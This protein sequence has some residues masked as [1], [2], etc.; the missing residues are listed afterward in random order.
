M[1]IGGYIMQINTPQI[2]SYFS[3]ISQ[4]EIDAIIEN[5]T[6]L[7]I[8]K[9]GNSKLGKLIWDFSLPPVSSCPDSTKC[10]I[11]CYAVKSYELYKDAKLSWNNNFKLVINDIDAFKTL[12]INQLS[13]G[14]IKTLRIHA[15]GDFYSMEYL[16]AWLEIINQFPEINFFAYTKSF[17]GS[18]LI[19][20]K[21]LN[22]IDSF[23]EVD[24]VKYLN[25]A[26]YHIIKRIRQETK[27]IICPVTKGGY[28]KK[29]HR[30]N[31]DSVQYQKGLKLSK[32]TCSECEFCITKTNVLFIEHN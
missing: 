27:A 19:Q 22:I 5:K 21:N 25:Y 12:V 1:S 9:K 32:I 30:K 2:D 20:P 11:T 10:A 4:P 31:K 16:T 8:L 23:V 14:K 15:S 24:G 13:K 18:D 26:E 7:G 17:Q 6:R 3:N 29:L 28:L